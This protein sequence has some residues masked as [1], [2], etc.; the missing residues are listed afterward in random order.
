MSS[1]L[2]GVTILVFGPQKMR[3]AH[4]NVEAFA[5]RE[6]KHAPIW[7]DDLVRVLAPEAPFVSI[8]I[9]RKKKRKVNLMEYIRYCFR[10]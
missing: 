9:D 2:T 1:L 8:P 10:H 5:K 7:A 6:H 4:V 3:S